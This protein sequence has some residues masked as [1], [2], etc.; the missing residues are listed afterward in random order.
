VTGDDNTAIGTRSNVS[1][2]GLTNATAIGH[3]AVVDASNKVR[4][5]NA[6]VSVIE[7]QVPYTYTSDRTQKENV[8]A[9]DGDAVLR[10]LRHLGVFTWNYI[11][12]DPQTFRHYGPMAQDFFEAFGRDG[13]GRV[14]TPTTINSGDLDGVLIA[15]VQALDRRAAEIEELKRRIE[16]LEALVSAQGRGR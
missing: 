15:A 11:G 8:L 4:L 2:D 1:R 10:R 5:G 13:I 12:Q 14:G 3:G 7:G 6:Q 16:A 9:V